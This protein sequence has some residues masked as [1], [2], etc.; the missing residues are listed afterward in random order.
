MVL[1]EDAAIAA[2]A[3]ENRG[4]PMTDTFTHLCDWCSWV[5]SSEVDLQE[6]IEECHPDECQ[7]E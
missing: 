3:R 2:F 5:T 7:E 6:H 1:E 4:E